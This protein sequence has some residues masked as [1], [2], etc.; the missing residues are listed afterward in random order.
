M[1]VGTW[2]VREARPTD[3]EAIASL[4]REG[5]EGMY[6]FDWRANAEALL[7]AF[8]SGKVALGVAEEKG[9]V[10][11]YCNLRAWPAGGWIDQLVVSRVH[12][13]KGIGRALMKFMMQ[14]AME[15]RFWKVSLIVSE[16]DLD[17][18]GFYK[19]YGFEQA[20]RMRDEISR[21]TDGVLLSYITDYALHPNR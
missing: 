16:S 4:S 19:S 17:A 18:L 21:G 15:R 2:I 10:V 7:S 9:A 3:V 11:G 20:G 1:C 6:E 14:R 8:D 13:R 12:R 5:F